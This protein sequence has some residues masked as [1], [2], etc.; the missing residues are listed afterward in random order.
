MKVYPITLQELKK[1]RQSPSFYLRERDFF[2]CPSV[3]EKAR[4][5]TTV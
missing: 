3:T 2:D 1:K 4:L 5:S